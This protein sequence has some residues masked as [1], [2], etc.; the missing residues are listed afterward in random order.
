MPKI[1]EIL[2]KLEAFHY[3]TS[4]DLNMRYYY[5]QLIKKACNLC[6]IIITWGKYR[7]KRLPTGV[8]DS[9]YIFHHKMTD[10]FHGLEFGCA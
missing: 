2:L 9:P 3:D 10:L 6:T 4:L 7:V 8:A 1:N 5:I